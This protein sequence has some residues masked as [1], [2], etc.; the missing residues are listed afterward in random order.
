MSEIPERGPAA[1]VAE[2]IGTFALIFFIT[3]TVSLYVKPATPSFQPFIDFSVIGLVHVLALFMLVQTLAVVSGAHFNPAV[4]LSLL[5]IRQIRVADA[6]I[7]W[8]CQFAGGIAAALVTKAIVGH[9][10]AAAHYGAPG[11]SSSITAFGGMCAEAIGTF[12]LVWAIV[13]V[14]VNPTAVRGWAGLV[15]GG[16]LG[17]AVMAIGPVTGGSFNPARAFG[18]A[19]VSHGFSPNAIKWILTYVVAAGVG[20]VLAAFAYHSMF[21]LP[22]KK[23][24]EGMSPVG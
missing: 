4:T 9:Q 22:G 23:G 18:P 8:L 6:V 7:Y 2:F 3:F 12:F 5:A 14:A 10:G 21:I 13:G 24:T 20:G 1:F 16:A 19:L 15:I 11:V 17:L